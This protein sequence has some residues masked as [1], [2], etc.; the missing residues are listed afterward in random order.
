MRNRIKENRE[1]AGLTQQE[2]ADKAGCTRQFINMLENNPEI[3][4][5][6]NTLS[7]IAA[8]LN[9]TVDD[10]IFFETNV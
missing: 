7:R 9:K 1:E 3:N 4:V 6:I 10:L 5:S 8:A 2:L